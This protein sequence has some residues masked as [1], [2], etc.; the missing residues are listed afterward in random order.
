MMVRQAELSYVNGQLRLGVQLFVAACGRGN[1]ACACDIC[2]LCATF[3]LTYTHTKV[4]DV[5]YDLP[6]IFE[7]KLR[8]GFTSRCTMY[9]CNLH[10]LKT[11]V[12]LHALVP[13]SGG[14]RLPGIK[15]GMGGVARRFSEI[16]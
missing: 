15:V 13:K 11:C 6:S 16:K 3:C 14:W 12:K 2:T 8:P 4:H 7:S 9:I 10:M 5:N 1:Q